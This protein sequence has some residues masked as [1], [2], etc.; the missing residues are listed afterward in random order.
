MA[1]PPNTN[2][3]SPGKYYQNDCDSSASECPKC[4]LILKRLHSALEEIESSKLSTELLQQENTDNL[5][6]ANGISKTTYPPN[7]SS[8]QMNWKRPNHKKWIVSTTK[9]HKKSSRLYPS[10]AS[11]RD[12]KDGGADEPPGI[13]KMAALMSRRNWSSPSPPHAAKN[14]TFTP[15][16][17]PTSLSLSFH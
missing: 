13:L 2:I 15:Y 16:H 17:S 12:F 4:L 9:C 8:T 14:G 5:N 11:A 6:E 3:A 1:A 7:N 10:I